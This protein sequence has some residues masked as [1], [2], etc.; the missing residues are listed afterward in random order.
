VTVYVIHVAYEPTVLGVFSNKLSA[1]QKLDS[2]AIE[3]EYP[4]TEMWVEEYEVSE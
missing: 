1:E 4:K 2:L 3:N